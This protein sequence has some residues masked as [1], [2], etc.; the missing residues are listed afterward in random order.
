MT[1]IDP[2]S[3][4]VATKLKRE[5]LLKV[6]LA[7]PRILFKIFIGF[8]LAVVLTAVVQ[9]SLALAAATVLS[10]APTI[11]YE[12]LHRLDGFRID[13]IKVMGSWRIDDFAKIQSQ[14]EKIAAMENEERAVLWPEIDAFAAMLH[15]D[16]QFR[17]HVVDERIAINAIEPP[18]Q[19]DGYLL[20]V[21]VEVEALGEYRPWGKEDED[22]F[23]FRLVTY[24]AA[25]EMR[26]EDGYVFIEI[27]EPD[28][29]FERY[30][31]D[32]IP[33]GMIINGHLERET[34]RKFEGL[35]MY[36]VE[37]KGPF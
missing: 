8:I 7:I 36:F 15:E 9:V 26:G 28:Y 37:G 31:I 4:R 21:E 1:P 5:I 2:G 14:A 23:K 6:L 24:K 30:A 13:E 17:G 33:I 22:I 27:K 12:R 19:T 35:A 10:S 32:H 3:S 20:W 11:S 25:D 18:L 34:K 29:G 16:D